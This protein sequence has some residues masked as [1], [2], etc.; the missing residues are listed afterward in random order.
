MSHSE[1]PEV[2]LPDTSD[3][4]SYTRRLQE[5]LRQLPGGELE[6]WQPLI[7]RGLSEAYQGGDAIGLVGMLKVVVSF[8]DVVGR[9]DAA[10]TQIDHVL[11]IAR[12]DLEAAPI[13]R[14]LRG[15]YLVIQGRTDEA[16][17]DADAAILS[18]AE[19][20]PSEA[21][22]EAECHAAAIRLFALE[23][24]PLAT[25]DRLVHAT[26]DGS[27]NSS[28]LFLS[29]YHIPYLFARA[30]RSA[31]EP[32]L[33]AF[34][35]GAEA[36]N[37]EY[38][39]ADAAVFSDAE[40]AMSE[41]SNVPSRDSIARWNWLAHWRIQLLRFRAAH[42]R[43]DLAS[44]DEELEALLNAMD[45]GGAADFG[46]AE[47]FRAYHRVQSGP[48][49]TLV[50]LEPP[51]TAHLLNLP[52]ILAGGEAVAL[53]GSQLLARQW[54]SWF[55]DQLPAHI[56]TSL[57]WPVSRV[58]I[59]ALLALRSTE[60]RSAADLFEK[61][62]TWSRRAGYSCELAIAGIQAAELQVHHVTDPSRIHAEL[63][64]QRRKGW[65]E[66][67]AR[68]I[69]PARYAYQVAR[70][71][72]WTKDQLLHAQLTPRELQVL[73]LLVEGQS[74]KQMAEHLGVK[75]PT[76]QVLAHRCYEKLG[77]SGK[78]SAVQAARDQGIL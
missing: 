44:A 37:H 29:S 62:V 30:E 5:E 33:R 36:A 47:V 10:V 27:R 43:G 2:A 31:A 20:T 16:L 42:L 7:D 3:L 13:L 28:S 4:A 55:R 50:Q 72:T 73:G 8:L 39:L 25:V 48:G 22:Q 69:E 66:L 40:G 19:Q 51:K 74:Y 67:G 32:R 58:R 26:G 71:S 57:E 18:L 52:S 68:G 46:A 65:E 78:L 12:D 56:K 49:D 64:A 59:E 24:T 70:L 35:L 17:E 54:L 77:A 38:R 23:N 41:P 75:W 53:G 63:Q 15:C 60:L 76:V 45:A 6:D 1:G 61:A 9:H 34:R 21:V 14:A 11:N